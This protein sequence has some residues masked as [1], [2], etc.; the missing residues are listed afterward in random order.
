M[1]AQA[2]DV[3]PPQ[4]A[5]AIIGMSGRFPGAADVA[6]FWRNLAEGVESIT[7]FPPETLEDAFPAAIRAQPN[8]VPARSILEGVELFDAGF[9]EMLASE[10]ALTDPQHRIF[11]EICWEALEDAG[12][13]PAAFAGPI[14]VFAGSSINT[15]LLRNVCRD[16]QTI[17][18]FTSDYQVGSYPMLIG[19]GQ[20]FLA[21][22]VAYKFDLRGPAMTVQSACSTALLAVAQACQSLLLYQSDMALAGAVSV[23]LPQHRGYLYQDGGM[24]SADGH[25][26][27]F[28]D[29]ADG[30]VFGAG[31]GVVLLKRLEDALAEGDHVY[32]VIRGHG[33]SND[34]RGKLGYTAPSADG[35]AAAIPAAQAM[36]GV[37]PGSIGYVECHGT[38]TPLGDPIEFAGL[39]KAFRAGTEARGFCRLGSVKPN[40]GHLDVAAGAAGLIK[41]AL[42]LKHAR[43][44]GLLHFR[45]PNSRIDLAP[46]PF[47]IAAEAADWP[48]GPTPRRAGVSAFGVGGTNVHLVLEEAPHRPAADPARPWQVLT[49]SARS[50]AALSAMA[51]RLAAALAG[52]PPDSLADIA[53]TLQ[54]GRRGF[55]HRCA[56]VVS[57]LAQ[58]AASLASPAIRFASSEAPPPPVGFLFPGQGAQRVG[59]GEALYQHEPVFR[60]QID[61]CSDILA[62][63]LGRHLR[64]L[65][66]PQSRGAQAEQA[67]QATALAQPA[68]FCVEYALAQ[69]LIGW[70]VA[71]AAM[72]G[73]S[74]GEYVAACL[75]GV[76]SLEDAL[77]VVAWRGQRMQDLEGGVMLAVRLGEAELQPLLGEEVSIAAVNAPS[78]CVASGPA[79]A[80]AEL[81]RV[82]AARGGLARRLRTSHAFHSAMM[83]PMLDDLEARM[84]GIRLSPPRIAYVSGVTG[85]WIDA[86]EA[87][88]PRYWARHSRAPVRFA[89]GLACLAAA[90]RPV[91]LEVGPGTALA[92]LAQQAGLKPRVA[93]ILSSL[94]DEPA[95]ETPPLPEAGLPPVPGA[96]A[97]PSREPLHRPS[98]GP[99]CRPSRE[100]LHRPSLE[101][102]HRPSR[103]RPI[104]LPPHSQR[105]G[106]PAYSPIGRRCTRLT[107]A[108]GS[109][110]R[111]IR[112]SGPGTGSMPLPALLRGSRRRI[113]GWRRSNPKTT[114][115]REPHRRGMPPRRVHQ[116][117]PHPGGRVAHLMPPVA[118]RLTGMEP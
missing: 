85:Q 49:L 45:T 80:I 107:D 91:L 105:S 59:M 104:P 21:T 100:P 112:S 15:Y 92:R 46:S 6:G 89:D 98:R 64:D 70:G 52:A 38:A 24:V 14:G 40:V 41:A 47:V 35:Q 58:A 29:A 54:T 114:E 12:Y 68:L 74:L 28:D 93:A 94:P 90:G 83:D 79:P 39:L 50:P 4:D 32:A 88:S 60:R 34:G 116:R 67:L 62:P 78:L 20:D 53:Y 106:P 9:F 75:A 25:C 48:A 84:A 56:V 7:R 77:A 42:A 115:R 31:A 96:T 86:A 11:L 110:C 65:L 111:P 51:A 2:A 95:S 61:A 99:P 87:T 101:P 27:T 19:G 30:T 33:I 17:E 118:C 23:S 55:R 16:R 8:Y 82:L 57:S 10:A 117:R 5:I 113:S 43:L 22:R 97:P 81:E 71:P 44:P 63:L 13:D 3:A 103:A 76:M 73:H 102:L 69:L 36:A 72:L 109:R 108:A 26:R 1:S 37:S 18:T 66:Y